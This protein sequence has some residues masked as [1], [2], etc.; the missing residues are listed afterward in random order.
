MAPYSQLTATLA[1][2]KA[3]LKAI[4]R[5]PSAVIF[6]FAFPL[7]FILAFGFLGKSGGNIHTI[8]LDKTCDTANIFYTALKENSNIRIAS[9]NTDA[10]LKE[11]LLKGKITGILSIQKNTSTIA[12]AYYY[13]F[14]STTASADKYPQLLSL[15]ENISNQLKTPYERMPAYAIGKTPVIEKVREYKDIDFILPGQLGF[16]LLSAAVFG[17]AFMFFNLR[18]TLVL[19]RFFATPIS[20]TNIILG[21]G[22]SRVLFQLLTAIVIILIGHFFF[23]FSHA[24]WVK[25]F[26]NYS[27]MSFGVLYMTGLRANLDEYGVKDWWKRLGWYAAQILLLPVFSLMES[28]GVLAAIFR[29]VAGFH[30]VKK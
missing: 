30:V 26:A 27:F 9:F 3:S 4:F 13:T 29:P 2:T 10:A 19:K 12:P 16:S 7:I 14:K 17:V 23:G 24:W 21:E 5:S 15:L 6:G 28:L 20:R 22:L 18:N 1:I 11:N 8:V 25:L